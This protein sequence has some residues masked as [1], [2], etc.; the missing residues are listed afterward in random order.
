MHRLS[1]TI[2]FLT[3]LA[4]FAVA[5]PLLAQDANQP[6]DANKSD[7]SKSDDG[8]TGPADE[9]A[10]D[11]EKRL[12]D[13]LKPK[14]G[15]LGGA[16]KDDPDAQRSPDDRA[17]PQAAGNDKTADGKTGDATNGGRKASPII[18]PAIA[19]IGE[20]DS[21]D[22]RIVGIAPGAELPKLR[23]EG[24]FVVNRRGRLLRTAD[25]A[26]MFSFDA[27]SRRAPEPPM[28]LM[29]CRMLQNMEQL[30]KD[31]GDET[32]FVLSGQVFVYRGANYLLPTMMKPAIDKGNLQ[33]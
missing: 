29:P 13:Q 28:F 4:A 23:R 9:S 17:K 12:R 18:R 6:A 19:N 26:A 21:P 1:N 24:E 14:P 7:T 11:I 2:V 33:Q 27:D 30:A 32:V 20:V 10:A 5:L 8:K 25:G 15:D 31:H 3:L 16:N 22:P